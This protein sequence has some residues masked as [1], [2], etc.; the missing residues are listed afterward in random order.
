MC[1]VALSKT[2][3]RE[4]QWRRHFIT[5]DFM[6]KKKALWIYAG[7]A[8]GG[9]MWFG[10][11]EAIME[12]LGFGSVAEADT[13]EVDAISVGGGVSENQNLL[14]IEDGEYPLVNDDDYEF[15]PEILSFY[16]SDIGE[17]TADGT[18]EK[19]AFKTLA[20]A[21]GAALADDTHKRIVVLTDLFDENLVTFGQSVGTE[22]TILIEGK[23][24]TEKIERSVGAN[25]SVLAITGGAKIA[26]K[27][28]TINGKINPDANETDSNNPALKITGAGTKVTLADGTVVT[29]K[30]IGSR[31]L[32][33]TEDDGSGVLVSGGAEL[34]MTGTAK[35]TQCV[36]EAQNAKGT[37][38]V[39][40]GSKLTMAGGVISHNTATAINSP[41][42]GGGVYLY[43]SALVMTGGAVISN[44]TASISSNNNNINSSSTSG[45]GISCFNS[46]I[47]MTDAK[48][49]DNMAIGT[50]NNNG[51]FG[52]GI[53]CHTGTITMNSN[54]VISGNETKYGLANYGGGVYLNSSATLI[55][56][57]GSAINSNTAS[58]GSIWNRGGGVAVDNTGSSFT[59][60]GGQI[61][62]NTSQGGGVHQ[63]SGTFAMPGGTI[64]ASNNATEGK[65]YYYEGG[66]KPAWLTS[67]SYDTE[68][69]GQQ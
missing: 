3:N 65:V 60:A 10:G 41:A 58:G 1:V 57:D 17:D 15:D 16:V 69:I 54:A 21:Y 20:Y 56:N 11:C 50:S 6:K 46:T 27:Q 5:E 48:I 53:W 25:D 68:I 2:G 26:F 63:R 14:D 43:G 45:G 49:T 34:V 61:S 18:T 67:T 55:M 29:G 24:G 38:V 7:L 52:G 23:T 37:V 30:K 33:A 12:M 28:I 31:N 19:T 44:N 35:V 64:T 51:T 39:V 40:G 32:I 8:I 13:E 47:T 36:E 66:T 4:R 9:A 62:G 59:M 42:Y 22:G